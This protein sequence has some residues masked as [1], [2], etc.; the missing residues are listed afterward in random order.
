MATILPV[1]IV[2]VHQRITNGQPVKFELIDVTFRVQITGR[3]SRP[4]LLQSC[5]DLLLAHS[6]WDPLRFFLEGNENCATDEEGK[7]IASQAARSPSSTLT[8]CNLPVSTSKMKPPTGMSLAIQG[9][10]L[11]FL[12]CPRVFCSG[13]L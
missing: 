10:N 12:I 5:S 3:R 7:V 9:C 2:K 1:L 8:S 6:H 13:S 4:M 11:T